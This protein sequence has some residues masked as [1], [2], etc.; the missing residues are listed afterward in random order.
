[1]RAFRLTLGVTLLLGLALPLAA[2]RRPMTFLDA[3]NMRQTSGLVVSPDGKSLAYALS[4]PDW[5]QARRQSDIYVVGVDGGMSTTRQLTFT[6][7]KNETSPR[8]SPDGKYIAFLSDRDAPAATAAGGGRGTPAATVPIPNPNPAGDAEGPGPSRNQIFVI[9]LDGGEARRI[10]DAAQGVSSF[11]FSRDGKSIVYATGRAREQQVYAV[12]T[13]DLWQGDVPKPAQ[14]T[15]HATGI[16]SWQWSPDGARIYFVAPDSID[17]DDRARIAQGFTV[18]PR[19]QATALLSLWAFDVT[20]KQERRLTND[21]SYSVSDVTVSP[22]GKWIGYRGLDSARYHRGILEQST[23][24]EL[25]LLNTASGSVERL[26]R[27]T[28]I[29]ESGVSFSRDSKLIAFT[30][31]NDFKFMRNDKVYVRHVDQPTEA[32][33]KIGGN[34]DL[35]IRVG[36]RGAGGEGAP[37]SSFWST[38]SDSVYFATGVKATTQVFAASV[39]TGEARQLTT[40]KATTTVARDE[41]SGRL[42]VSFADPSS[43]PATYAVASLRDLNDRAKWTLLIDGNAWVKRDIALGTG[44]EVT[45]KSTDGTMVGGVLVKPVGYQPGRRYPLIVAMHGGPAAADV[46]G[47]NGGYNSQVY[48]GAG[49]MVLQPNYRQSV[50]YGEKFK[51]ESQGDYFTKGY[52]DIMAGVD[53]LIAQGLVDSTQMGALGWSAGG[54]YSNWILTHTTRFKAISSGAGVANWISMWSQSDTHRLREWY[55]GDKPYWDDMASWWR[56]SPIATIKNAK[57]PIFLHVVYGDPRVPRPQSEEM[58]QALNEL[59]VPHEFW[60]YPGYA[61]GIPDVRNQ[62]AKAVAEMSWMDYYVRGTGKKFAWRDVLKAVES[63]VQMAG[64]PVTPPDMR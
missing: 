62:Y 51:I 27:N 5:Q 54:H 19:N 20:G 26:T 1:M 31:P 10:T 28:E 12:A 37:E 34:V 11:S 49:Y 41:E 53:Y 9:R 61:H 16:V 25:Y 43:P 8:W 36:G 18:A 3:Q 59:G 2:Q 42:I 17:R 13:A 30:A 48:A 64:E 55:V 21:A 15:R 60:V 50:N 4:I 32:W 6:G 63:G 38:A 23:Y 33:K 46:L 44:E 40:A 7:D 24:G 14:W 35:D 45:W 58:N 56:Q 29:S 39:L 52:Q 57:T 47:F 22:D